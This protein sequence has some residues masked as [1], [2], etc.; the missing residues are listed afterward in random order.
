MDFDVVEFS[1][2]ILVDSTNIGISLFL[3]NLMSPFNS[4]PLSPLYMP[5]IISLDGPASSAPSNVNTAT[6]SLF[7]HQYLH[8]FMQV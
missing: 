3:P 6:K 4:A 1:L 8:Q 2:L 7:G 5:Q